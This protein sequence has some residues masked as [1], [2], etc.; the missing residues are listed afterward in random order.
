[1]LLRDDYARRGVLN[2]ESDAF[3]RI[4]WIE[5]NISSARLQHAQDGHQ[6]FETSI[7]ADTDDGFRSH[8]TIDQVMRK[9]VRF[10]VELAISQLPATE[11][12]RRGVRRLRRLGLEKL[13]HTGRFGI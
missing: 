7:Q 3:A 13:L 5:R 2:H 8:A 9:L 4:S 10:A 11:L 6:H 1:M 12:Y